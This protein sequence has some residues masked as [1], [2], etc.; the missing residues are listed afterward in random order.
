MKQLR[1]KELL[2]YD[3]E[4][5]EFRRRISVSSNARA[6]SVIGVPHTN[7]YL[8]A[9]IDGRKYYLHRLAWLYV[10]G[11]F[12]PDEIDH[13]NRKRDD[14]RVANLRPATRKQNCR[15]VSARSNSKSGIRGVC[16]SKKRRTWEAF[17]NLDGKSKYLGSS[18]NRRR[19]NLRHHLSLW[20]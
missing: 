17:I 9:Q 10:H 18:N 7:G 19:R 6:G 13:I 4:S 5:G 14:N 11:E 16:W 1:L 8:I 3:P 2:S 20:K 15:N 12:P